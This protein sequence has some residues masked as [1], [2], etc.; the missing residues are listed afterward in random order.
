M[1][2]SEL[3]PPLSMGLQHSHFKPPGLILFFRHLDCRFCHET[4]RSLSQRQ[5]QLRNSELSLLFIH[6]DS[7]ADFRELASQYNLHNFSSISDPEKEYYLA[8][9]VRRATYRQ[10]YGLRPWLK[11]LFSRWQNGSMSHRNIFDPFQMS[12]IF[13]VF[14]D[15]VSELYR[16]SYI[17]DVP[18]FR[19]LIGE[20]EKHTEWR[21]ECG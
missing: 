8:F 17:G 6:M 13:Y 2:I 14:Q 3:S 18:D 11:L 19:R 7:D 5:K 4:L 20:I 15:R 9:G 21:E 12:G 10:I 1:R 16:P